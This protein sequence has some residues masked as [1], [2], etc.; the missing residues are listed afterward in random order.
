M[1]N[2]KSKFGRQTRKWSTHPCTDEVPSLSITSLRTSG[3]IVEGETTAGVMTWPGPVGEPLLKADWRV[4]LPTKA[5]GADGWI[6]IT[7]SAND[8]AAPTQRVPMR[9]GWNG[10]RFVDGA[11]MGRRVLYCRLNALK[12]ASA[13][14]HGLRHPSRLVGPDHRTLSHL[15]H[16]RRRLAAVP[17]DSAKARK[18][19]EGITET[20]QKAMFYY[21]GGRHRRAA[22]APHDVDDAAA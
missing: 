16:L 20:E 22:P 13:I 8:Q 21:A 19:Q 6:D 11:G 15:H 10:W 4:Y 3:A 14:E 12:F 5:D 7:L 17:P 9:F 18:L 2:Y 1:A